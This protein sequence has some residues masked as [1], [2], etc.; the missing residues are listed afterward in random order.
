MKVSC[1]ACQ[2]ARVTGTMTFCVDGVVFAHALFADWW[3]VAVG[4]DKDPTT[5]P[6]AAIFAL[7]GASSKVA[8]R[9]AVVRHH[10]LALAHV[11]KA[12]RRQ[13]RGSRAHPERSGRVS[14]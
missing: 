11:A 4:K 1:S 14:W 3:T 10:G 6:G 2:D 12:K 8:G 7:T 9:V 13:W 5:T